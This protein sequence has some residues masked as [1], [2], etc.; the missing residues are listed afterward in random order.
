MH[1]V[2]RIRRRFGV[3]VGRDVRDMADND[4]RLSHRRNVAAAEILVICEERERL[5]ARF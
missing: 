3:T 1:R 5:P 2:F 4:R